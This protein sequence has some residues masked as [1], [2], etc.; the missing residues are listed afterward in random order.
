MGK[1][2]KRRQRQVMNQM[3]NVSQY[4]N[5]VSSANSVAKDASPDDAIFDVVK[6]VDKAVTMENLFE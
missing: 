3:K 5:T 6:G 4:P 1:R 2:A